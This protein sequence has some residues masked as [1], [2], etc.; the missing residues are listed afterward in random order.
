M[1]KYEYIIRS[2]YSIEELG[3]MKHKDYAKFVEFARMN[4]EPH[5]RLIDVDAFKAYMLKYLIQFV[6]HPDYAEAKERIEAL[7][8]DLDEAPTVLEAFNDK[9]AEA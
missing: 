3:K 1:A 9:R 8:K 5:G 6:T 7:F 4:E 2:N